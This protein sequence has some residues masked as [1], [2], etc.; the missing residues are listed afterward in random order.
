MAVKRNSPAA[1]ALGL[2]IAPLDDQI[3]QKESELMETHARGR[4][5]PQ[6]F[7]RARPE[8]R[9]KQPTAEAVS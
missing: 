5:A 9:L 1:M 6:P 7:L 2:S 3:R 8:R 4:I